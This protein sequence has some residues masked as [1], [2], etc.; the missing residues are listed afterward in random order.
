MEL[1]HLGDARIVSVDRGKGVLTLTL[2]CAN[3]DHLA[4]PIQGLRFSDC[5]ILQDADLT[6]CTWHQH[7]L[8]VS[9]EFQTLELTVY[10]PSTKRRPSQRRF[11]F[12]FKRM[13]IIPP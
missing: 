2:D 6:G 7:S 3:A 8:T 9:T 13:E 1:D 12:R 10:A 4:V 5:S 11:V